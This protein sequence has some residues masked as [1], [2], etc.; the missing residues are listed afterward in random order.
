MIYVHVLFISFP[1]IPSYEDFNVRAGVLDQPLCSGTS[2][3]A[4]YFRVASTQDIPRRSLVI[5]PFS[6]A[7]NGGLCPAP[8]AIRQGTIHVATKIHGLL[9]C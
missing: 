2:D 8:V 1:L 3:S 7:C 9:M 6:L 4:L 5:R